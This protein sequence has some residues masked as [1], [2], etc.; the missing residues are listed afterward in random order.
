MIRIVK[1]TIP[2]IFLLLS[3]GEADQDGM[4]HFGTFS[5][6]KYFRVTVNYLKEPANIQGYPCRRGKVRFHFNDSLLSFKSAADIR[7]ANGIIPAGSTIYL[8]NNGRPENV[9]LS[10]DT[11]IQG[12]KI[13]SRE[14][15]K[16]SLLGFYSG[17]ELRKFMPVTDV[18]VDGISCNHE[19]YV[20]LYPDGSLM[21]CHLSRDVR[22]MDQ[23]FPAGTP[24]LKDEKGHIH[25][26]AFP[27]HEAIV[28][29]M[30]IE[31]DFSKPLLQAYRKRMEG[32]V[33]SVRNTFKPNQQD[34]NAMNHYESARIKRHGMIGGREESLNSY[35]YSASRTQ[36]G[37]YNV[38]TAFFHAE[39]MLY[40][41]RN[42][43]NLREE[44]RES[45]FYN[46]AINGFER[47]L[48]MKPDYH[49]ARLHLVDIY[50]HIPED[51]GGDREK[52]EMHAAELFK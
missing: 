10:G 23:Y 28:T 43:K 11:E 19:E 4:V 22:E 41:E 37:D 15:L 12:Y 18:D 42:K 33:D 30:N 7:L 32:K 24:I 29:L 8:Y 3:C 25:P 17:G 27:I 49:A 14:R 20:V 21:S 9:W 45:N 2:F 1:W 26:Y 51:L 34:R 46:P 52:A 44:S 39:S 47:V 48:E 50:S 5:N 6:F 35:L 13:S 36:T 38:I 16:G 31:K 40:V